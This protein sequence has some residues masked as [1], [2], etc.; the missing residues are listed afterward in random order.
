MQLRL[1]TRGSPLA[2]TQSRWVAARL[3]AGGDYSVELVTIRTS[4]DILRESPL[5]QI[6]GKGVF[7]R[8]LDIALLDG[9]IDLAV[10]SLKDL[11]TEFPEGLALG[12]VPEREDVRDVLVGPEGAECTLSSLPSGARVGTSS[13]RR[14]ALLKTHRSDVQVEEIRGNVETRIGK[15][16][17]GE[18]D[19]VVLAAAGVRRL[20]LADRISDALDPASWLPAP[21]QGA[22]A[23]VVRS[24]D[25]DRL[26]WLGLLDDEMAR[27]ATTAERTLLHTLE[28]GCRLPVAAL[29]LP[30]PGGLRLKAIVASPDGKQV[31]RGEGSAA[32]VDASKLGEEVAGS[33]IE[34]GADLLLADLRASMAEEPGG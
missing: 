3:E 9:E 34:R 26:P 22:L 21:G 30:Y 16:D 23:V 13:L 14:M 17:K 33:L 27:S 15:V 32:A 6:G 4:G 20:G 11:P 29:G 31:V 8:E 1:G 5:S 7:T 24:E 28:A 18:Y 10:H 12:A 25:V 19:A 2:L